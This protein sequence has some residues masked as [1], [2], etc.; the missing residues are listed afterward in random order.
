M[1]ISCPHLPD[2]GLT[3]SNA[4]W[5]KERRL[6]NLTTLQIIAKGGASVGIKQRHVFLGTNAVVARVGLRFLLGW[7]R[8][9][10]HTSAL[11]GNIEGQRLYGR[12]LAGILHVMYF[13]G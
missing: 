2:D 12:G 1:T 13:T 3:G 7:D 4:P 5:T 9:V 10:F 11:L 6:A 8:Q